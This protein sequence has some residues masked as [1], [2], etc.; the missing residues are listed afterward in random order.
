MNVVLVCIFAVLYSFIGAMD[1]YFAIDNFKEQKYFWFGFWVMTA[2]TQAA[3]IFDLV[4]K[5]M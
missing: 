1:I 5:H 2:I 4:F 3:Y